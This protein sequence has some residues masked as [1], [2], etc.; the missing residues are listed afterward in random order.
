MVMPKKTTLLQSTYPSCTH[1]RLHT[2]TPPAIDYSLLPLDMPLSHTRP[3]PCFPQLPS[4]LL[5]SYGHVG[6]LFDQILD[7]LP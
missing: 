1:T 2:I 7:S 4:N 6:I 3:L 5:L